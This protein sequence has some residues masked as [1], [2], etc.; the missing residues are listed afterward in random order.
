MDDKL[1]DDFTSFLDYE[2]E[3]FDRIEQEYSTDIRTALEQRYKDQI[4]EGDLTDQVGW[5]ESRLYTVDDRFSVDQYNNDTLNNIHAS[6]EPFDDAGIDY[7]TGVEPSPIEPADYDAVVLDHCVVFRVLDR[8]GM[9]F[10]QE[11]REQRDWQDV[12]TFIDTADQETD[13]YVLDDL[14]QK[15]DRVDFLPQQ[16]AAGLF[17]DGFKTLSLSDP[18][19]PPEGYDHM[20]EDLQIGALAETCGDDVIVATN[21]SDFDGAVSHFYDIEAGDPLLE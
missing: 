20:E 17:E 4:P 21:D 19:D 5:L 8:G 14:S 11:Q 7:V 10:Y 16:H 6:I 18:F 9:Q 3:V 1:S 12:L 2:T 13:V 15:L